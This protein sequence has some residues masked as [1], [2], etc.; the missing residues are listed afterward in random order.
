[1]NNL[2]IHADPGARSHF[3]ASWLHNKLDNA[4]FDVGATAN[5]P[6]VKIHYLENVGQ[7]T[8]FLGPRIRIKPTFDKL[9][10]HLL[11]F[12]R[13]NVHVQLPD[14]TKDE[15]S[16][17]TFSK[18]YIFAKE[19]LEHN[20]NLDYSLYNYVIKFEDT[21]DLEKLIELYQKINGVDPSQNN[22]DLAVRNNNI[23][24][25]EL[26]PNHA[27]SIAAMI[28][29]TESKLNLIEKNRHWSIPVLY[30]TT[31]I[32]ELYQMVKSKITTENYQSN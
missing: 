12:L 22:I 14:F 5:T 3:V 19:A 18:V 9:A 25:F 28:L 13:K 21:F 27:C 26:N 32:E 15:F 11:L 4:G 1:M 2:L 6:F 31:P 20:S 8:T 10:L 29:E 23:N 7:L 30:K 17:E 24:H 16:L